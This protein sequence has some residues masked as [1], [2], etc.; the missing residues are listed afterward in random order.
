MEICFGVRFE[1][2]FTSLRHVRGE[3]REGG[4]H[5][6]SEGHKYRPIFLPFR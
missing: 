1:A 4:E 5:T 3:I 6:G 2:H